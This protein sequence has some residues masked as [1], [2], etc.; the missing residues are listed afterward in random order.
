[1]F[2]NKDEEKSDILEMEE[3]AL[4][5]E[6]YLKQHPESY[7]RW[8]DYDPEE[9]LDKKYILDIVEL[10]Q[11]DEGG[12]TS[13]QIEDLMYLFLTTVGLMQLVEIGLVQREKINGISY[14]RVTGKVAKREVKNVRKLNRR[15]H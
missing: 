11:T 7:E 3:D 5:I 1:M 9:S 2:R 14:Y 15:N 8:K 4:K 6:N 12:L 10:F 13:K